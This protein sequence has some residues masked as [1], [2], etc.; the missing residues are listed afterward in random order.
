M[1]GQNESALG[2]VHF[3]GSPMSTGH[4]SN[5]ND[6]HWEFG[7]DRVFP[8]DGVLKEINAWCWADKTSSQHRRGVDNAEVKVEFIS[9][10]P[11]QVLE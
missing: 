6:G 1:R 11:C 8:C 9:E 7:D 4:V 2:V 3:V 10:L 5:V